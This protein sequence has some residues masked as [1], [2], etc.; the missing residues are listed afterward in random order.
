MFQTSAI[1]TYSNGV[2]RA[3]L[4]EDFSKYYLKL[5]KYY[6]YNVGVNFYF[7]PRYKPHVSIFIPQFHKTDKNLEKYVDKLVNLFYDPASIYEGGTKFS[8]YYLSIVSPD[9]EQIR[10]EIGVENNYQNRL[11]L[12]LFNNKF[13]YTQK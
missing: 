11:H 1:I 2:L 3:E 7:L 10:N 5:F 9:I 12:C 8:G 4:N 6:R 13:L